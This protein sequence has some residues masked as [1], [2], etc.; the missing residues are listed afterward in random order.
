MTKGN[1]MAVIKD[2]AARAGVS[3][4]TVSK[5]FNNPSGL[6][7]K[8]RL[9]VEEAVKELNYTP[10]EIARG[11]RTKK[12]NVIALIV[13]DIVNSFYSE[14]Y[15]YIRVAAARKNYTIQMYTTEDNPNILS[16]LLSQFSRSNIDGI[17]LGFL[18][19]DRV[20]EK[21]SSVES[22][23]PLALISWDVNTEFNS[24]ILNLGST[25]YTT[26]QH[27][28]SKGHKKIAYIGGILHLRISD[29]KIAGYKRALK[30][31]G[32]EFNED[33]V[34]YGKY[35][36]KSGYQAAQYFMNLSDPPTAIVGA[37]DVLAIG[38]C[39]YLQNNGYRIP[40]DVAVTG[41][42]GIQLA[43][44]YDPNITTMVMPMEEMCNELLE[45]LI[46]KIDRP[47]SKNRQTIYES[48]LLV[49]RSTDENA[50]FYLDF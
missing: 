34:Y 29:E 31:N 14:M 35:Q 39:K 13:P 8:C 43:R 32:L 46:N 3:I 11:L 48:K 10:N 15:D 7:D 40:Q 24:V 36:F 4:S 38:A 27:L 20:V 23:T 44:L 33:Y 49:G 26:T 42:D 25:I 19:D 21:L 30:D 5:Y 9:A 22:N 45:Y 16:E 1:L 47:G 37:N 2:V 17:I 6:S 12:T 50:P 41:M 28:I 18:D